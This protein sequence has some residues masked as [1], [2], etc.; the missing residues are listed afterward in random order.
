MLRRPRPLAGRKVLA[1]AKVILN[2]GSS[3]GGTA[4]TS[5]SAT[6]TGTT[7]LALAGDVNDAYEW[8]AGT[9]TFASGKGSFATTELTA[10]A[11]GGRRHRGGGWDSVAA[12][13]ACGGLAGSSAA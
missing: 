6:A 9:G 1:Q 2:A 8:G 11:T 3:D 12:G 7:A 10:T 5:G 13:A 4:T